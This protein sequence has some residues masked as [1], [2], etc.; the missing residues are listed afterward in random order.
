MFSWTFYTEMKVMR[1]QVQASKESC[2][3]R[4]KT[5]GMFRNIHAYKGFPL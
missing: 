4:G 3:K 1:K 2:G 5:K